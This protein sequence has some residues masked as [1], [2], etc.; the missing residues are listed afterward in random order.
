MWSSTPGI[1]SG[2]QNKY[3]SHLLYVS[4]CQLD[5]DGEMENL[6]PSAH[7]VKAEVLCLPRNTP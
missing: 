6:G 3:G 5:Y 2:F 7:M 1:S 4:N